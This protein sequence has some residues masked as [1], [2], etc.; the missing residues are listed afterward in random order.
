MHERINGWMTSE[1]KRT[2]RSAAFYSFFLYFITVASCTRAKGLKVKDWGALF[3]KKPECLRRHD[4][5]RKLEF[6]VG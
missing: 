3:K 4:H 6:D 5:S 2:R 1:R